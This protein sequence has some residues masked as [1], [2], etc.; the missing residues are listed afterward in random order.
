VNTTL[1]ADTA[2]AKPGSGFSIAAAF[3]AIYFIWGSTYLAIRFAL[4]SLPP[5]FLGAARF[6]IAGAVLYT[7]RRVSGDP[8]PRWEHWRAAAII[9]GLLLLGG[10]GGVCWA[11]QTVPSGA[12]ALLITTVPVWMVLLNW[13][14]RG[15]RRPTR[16][17]I[18]G[19]LLGFAGVV[20]LIGPGPLTG[21]TRLDPVGALV[22]VLASLSWSIGSI[23]SV[24]AKLPDSPFVATAM[25]MLCGGGLLLILSTVRGEP[26]GLA[27][28]QITLR[29][30]A[31]LAYLVM[32]GSLV[33]FTAYVWLLRVSTP[34]MVSTYAFVN[35]AVAVLLGC[36]LAGEPFTLRIL[37]AM[38]LI[39][40]GVVLITSARRA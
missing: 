22:L 1:R 24:R 29:S 4:E 9:G 36:L 10:N 30:V 15:G 17:E 33:A 35:P 3:A 14:R 18:L 21:G 12:A 32:F 34:A 39:V 8:R 23:Y 40:L 31:S 20:I 19:L 26:F 6:L 27:A 38:P 37:L 25:E 28:D 7:W 11:E 2:P 13:L 16:P 5:F